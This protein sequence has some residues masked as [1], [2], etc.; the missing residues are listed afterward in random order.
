MLEDFLKETLDALEK[1]GLKRHIR[2]L[3]GFQDAKVI[4]EN[5]SVLNFCSNNYLGLASDSRLGQAA[6]EGIKQFGFGSGASRMVCGNMT[7]HRVLEERL[8]RFKGTEDCLLF[9]SGYMANVGIISGIY[10]KDDIIFSDKLNHASIIDGILLSRASFKRYPHNDVEALEAML[11]EAKGFKKKVI[12]TDSVFSMDGDI[13]PL[14]DI[15]RLAKQY[16]CAVMADEAHAF[17]VLGNH[18]KGAVEHFGL[19]GEIDVQMGTLS[20]ALG[21]FGAYCCGS[22][23]LIEYLKNK[24]RSFIYTTAMPPSNAAAG[25]MALDIIER[26]SSLRESLWENTRYVKAQL[27]LMGFNILDSQTPIIPIVVGNNEKA[28]AFSQRLFEKGILIQ[29]I[30]PPTVPKNTA[31]LRLTIMATHHKNDL[32]YLLNQLQQIGKEL[33]L[34]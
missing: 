33:C 27:K 1:E 17:G 15:V 4:F 11:K 28:A 19:E 32:D 7:V 8:A 2:E 9:S 23:S 10:D 13:A 3:K 5:V 14:V 29:A 6:L 31:R 30:R 34:I 16:D 25:I 24:A 22:R 21:A 12:V 26:D 18:G 20:K